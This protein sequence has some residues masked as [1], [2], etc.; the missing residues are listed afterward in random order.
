[1][2]ILTITCTLLWLK[3]SK[4]VSQYR[5]MM[6]SETMMKKFLLLSLLCGVSFSASAQDQMQV[7]VGGNY[8]PSVY[9]V[10][11]RSGTVNLLGKDHLRT[12][13]AMKASQ[14]TA[15][16]TPALSI[17]NERYIPAA[18]QQEQAPP[19]P[20]ALAPLPE[21]DVG[22]QTLPVPPSRIE[23]AASASRTPQQPIMAPQPVT[24]MPLDLAMTQPGDAVA[25]PLPPQPVNAVQ[26]WRA[27]AGES[28]QEVITRWA[29][30]VDGKPTAAYANFVLPQD[31]SFFGTYDRAVERLIQMA[32]SAPSQPSQPP[33]SSQP[34]QAAPAMAEKPAQ[35]QQPQ[36]IVA[37]SA[38]APAQQASFPQ[39]D[40]VPPVQLSSPAGKWFALNGAPLQEVLKS[41]ADQ[42][43]VAIVW[44][45]NP[46]I[47]VK[48]TL[49]QTSSFE[50]AVAQLLGQYDQDALRPRGQLY[51]N[52]ADGGRVLVIREEQ[53]AS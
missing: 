8:R 1:M 42:A 37:P 26:G 31:F 22:M 34:P 32:A 2:V 7:G 38:P 21:Q 36:P 10:Q 52:P 43:G 15:P 49:S 25:Q 28:A 48:T 6:W 12:R 50:D 4:A 9:E 23:P 41:W 35:A 24:D 51:R 44:Q 20:Q 47:A 27:R 17:I 53:G 3:R 16:V 33:Q 46:S 5:L 30:R 29:E 39:T 45:A 14:P 11:T 13:Q 19:P 40:M 18:L